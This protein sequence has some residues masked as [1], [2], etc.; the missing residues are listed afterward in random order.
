MASYSSHVSA[1]QLTLMLMQA[2][3]W[4]HTNWRLILI[5][6]NGFFFCF[7]FLFLFILV[8]VI[9]VHVVVLFFFFLTI[10]ASRHGYCCFALVLCFLSKKKSF[11]FFLFIMVL[12]LFMLL[13]LLMLFGVFLLDCN[14]NC[15]LLSLWCEI[16]WWKTGYNSFVIN[17]LFST[18]KNCDQKK[19]NK[20]QIMENKTKGSEELL[21]K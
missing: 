1:L 18:H 10:D 11:S 15:L 13:L 14:W 5:K 16:C 7:S 8:I 19:K 4:T 17:T 3:E 20:R 21:S 2:L 6:L 9:V 12:L